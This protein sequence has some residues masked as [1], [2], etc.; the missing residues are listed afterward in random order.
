MSL[1]DRRNTPCIPLFLFLLFS[2]QARSTTAVFV[3]TSDGIVLATDSRERVSIGSSIQERQGRKTFIIKERFAAVCLGT[4]EFGLRHRIGG[5]NTQEAGNEFPS[6]ILNIKG[7]LS[8]SPSFDEVVGAI[9]DET[10]G[11]I[12]LLQ[13]TL[14]TGGLEQDRPWDIFQPFTSFVIAGYESGVPKLSIVELYIDWQNKVPLGPFQ[15]TLEPSGP[16]AGHMRTYMFGVQEAIAD[17][18]NPKSYAYQQTIASR[19]EAV[20]NLIPN[21][22]IILNKS[23]A[24]ARDL[25]AV[26]EK[27]NPDGVGGDIVLSEILHTGKAYDLIYNLPKPKSGQQTKRPE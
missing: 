7:R 4:C 25:V 18:R 1:F 19:S 26:E 10:G 22:T 24:L 3:I 16:I 23:R 11:M 6:W 2:A 14:G 12:P 17:F 9:R 21:G 15:R 20:Q 5:N 13:A 8:D 27:T